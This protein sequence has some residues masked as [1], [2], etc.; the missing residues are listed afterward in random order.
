MDT[1]K[2]LIP[3]NQI[4]SG[5]YFFWGGDY[6]YMGEKRKIYIWLKPLG[7]W[8]ESREKIWTQEVYKIIYW[9]E[10]SRKGIEKCPKK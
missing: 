3:F 7:E 4:A 8:R 1:Q 2:E 5:D 10:L 6:Y 9:Q